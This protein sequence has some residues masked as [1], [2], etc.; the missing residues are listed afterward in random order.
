MDYFPNCFGPGYNKK[1]LMIKR[2]TEYYR[3]HIYETMLSEKF[4]MPDNCGINLHNIP[5]GSISDGEY[6]I[7]QESIDQIMKELK[8]LGWET[9]LAYGNSVLFVFD[10]NNIPSELVSCSSFE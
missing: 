1:Q 5:F 8:E 4:K 6:T 3:K 10:K 7:Y 9:N 2:I